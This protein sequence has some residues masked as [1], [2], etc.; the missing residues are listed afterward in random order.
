[1]NFISLNPSKKY[2]NKRYSWVAMVQTA[3]NKTKYGGHHPEF[4]QGLSYTTLSISP[5]QFNSDTINIKGALDVSLTVTNTGNVDGQKCIDVF[6][7]DHYA[8]YAPDMKNLKYFT[9]VALAP[10]EK[11]QITFTL[12]SSTLFY[13]NE[14]GEMMFKREA[15][16]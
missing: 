11:K 6:L 7:Q 10:G 1:M 3:P 16:L 4:G 9:K 8:S 13:Y 12:D 15:L 14:K 2:M 5:I